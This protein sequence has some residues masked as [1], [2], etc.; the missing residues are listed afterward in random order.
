M[1]Q[2]LTSVALLILAPVFG[3]VAGAVIGVVAGLM[4]QA[5]GVSTLWRRIL[6]G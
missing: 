2:T 5:A 4:L 1:I 3:A 6:G